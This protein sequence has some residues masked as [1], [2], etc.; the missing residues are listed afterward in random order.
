MNS[1]L[2]RFDGGAVRD[3]D[4]DKLDYEGFLNPMVL[5]A[6]A[7]YMHKNRFLKDGTTRNSDNW[8]SGFGDHHFDVCMKSLTRHFMDLWMFHRGYQGR[9]SI[10]DALNGIL[11]NT[12]A[13][14]KILLD[15]RKKQGN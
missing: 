2:R 10:D 15:E 14:Y 6:Y 13:Y 9:D 4:T 3:T 11:F 12:M 8:Q 1:D 7:Q 5:E